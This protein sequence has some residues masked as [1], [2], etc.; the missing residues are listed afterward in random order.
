[1]GDSEQILS[2][3]KKIHS[4]EEENHDLRLQNS[5]L[6]EKY[7]LKCNELRTCTEQRNYYERKACDLENPLLSQQ[8]NESNYNPYGNKHDRDKINNKDN[9]F[10]KRIFVLGLRKHCKGA[11]NISK[12]MEIMGSYYALCGFDL[13]GHEN[14]IVD[15]SSCS[16]YCRCLARK[17]SYVHLAI[18]L[19]CGLF[20]GK[21]LCRFTD[22]SS[23]KGI[24]IETFGVVAYFEKGEYCDYTVDN[25]EVSVV[26]TW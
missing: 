19:F 20:K 2:L 7:E 5:K 23:L 1:M 15:E 11:K 18:E 12:V 21:Y 9:D 16:N 25:N 22:G 24:K 6:Q 17:V 13:K 8:S 3:Q 14:F 10:Y 26:L 4:L